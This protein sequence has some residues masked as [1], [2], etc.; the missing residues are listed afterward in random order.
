MH[1]WR[2]VAR[3]NTTL[4]RSIQE[5]VIEPTNVRLDVQTLAMLRRGVVLSR[6]TFDLRAAI[7]VV[8]DAASRYERIKR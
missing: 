4:S 8:I 1:A 3:G 2:A 6:I 7:R 5:V